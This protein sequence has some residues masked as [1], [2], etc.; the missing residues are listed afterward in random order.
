MHFKKLRDITEVAP[1]FTTYVRK[2]I[3]VLSQ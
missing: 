2:E 3:V 1:L